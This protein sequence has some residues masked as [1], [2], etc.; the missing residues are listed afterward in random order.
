M[1]LAVV[2]RIDVQLGFV[3][4]RLGVDDIA[5]DDVALFHLQR[6]FDFAIGGHGRCGEDREGEQQCGEQ[7]GH[8]I[9]PRM[10]GEFRR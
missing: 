4:A 7:H 5:L 9:L 3:V 8:K 1:R 2:T 6:P 10:L